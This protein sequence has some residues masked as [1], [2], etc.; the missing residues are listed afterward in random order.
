MKQEDISYYL[1]ADK[2]PSEGVLKKILEICEAVDFTG[3]PTSV[4]YNGAGAKSRNLKEAKIQD[5]L[6]IC[7]F[8]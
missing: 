5:F 6:K 2:I 4:F 3:S 7:Y 1:V 8:C